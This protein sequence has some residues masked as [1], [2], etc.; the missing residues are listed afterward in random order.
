MGSLDIYTDGSLKKLGNFA[1]FGGWGF[2]V[3]RDFNLIWEAAGGE[4]STTNQRMELTAICEALKYASTARRPCEA[5]NIYSDSAYAINCYLQGWYL[6]WQKNGWRNSQ[7]K[8]VANQDLWIQ[9]IPYFD[10]FWYRFIKVK[11]HSSNMWNNRCDDLAQK[12]ADQLKSGW[13]GTHG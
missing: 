12:A 11:G 2:L 8:D 5:V 1:T 4:E 9:I 13:R 7:N 6:T 10:N 3:I